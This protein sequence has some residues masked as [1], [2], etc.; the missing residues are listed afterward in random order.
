MT[1]I[2]IVIGLDANP[3]D[4]IFKRSGMALLGGTEVGQKRP[5]VRGPGELPYSEWRCL[6]AH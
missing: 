1:I 4:A 6:K 2:V 5:G 3:A